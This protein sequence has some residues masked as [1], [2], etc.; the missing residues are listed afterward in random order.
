MWIRTTS[1]RNNKYGSYS[2]ARA[3]TLTGY[4]FTA[5]FSEKKVHC[6]QVSNGNK[7]RLDHESFYQ[8]NIGRFLHLSPQECKNELTRLNL[9]PNEGTNRKL[10][11]FHVFPDVA[12]QAELQKHQGHIR[13][14]TKFLFH[15]TYN[16]HDK[17]WIPH[18]G[19]NNPS[20][21]KADTKLK[22]IKKNSFLFGKYNSKKYNLH[23]I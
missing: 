5:T 14:E 10:V 12:H 20:N 9:T 21:C 16:L 22:D 7:G 19:R 8:N 4:K 18:K 17:H 6:S 23:E 13:L 2:K 11:N 15:G 3:T 1:F